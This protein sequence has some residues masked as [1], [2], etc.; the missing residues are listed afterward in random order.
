[1]RPRQVLCRPSGAGDVGKPRVVYET[2]IVARASRPCGIEIKLD[3]FDPK[4]LSS[5]LQARRA[6]TSHAGGASHRFL[7]DQSTS[8]SLLLSPVAQR[9]GRGRERGLCSPFRDWFWCVRDRDDGFMS[10]FGELRSGEVTSPCLPCDR[11]THLT[12]LDSG[13][14]R[15]HWDEW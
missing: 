14:D 3:L 15:R 2:H 1:M 11:L 6:D 4:G 8:F 12:S 7:S 5:P 9:W 10:M 13:F